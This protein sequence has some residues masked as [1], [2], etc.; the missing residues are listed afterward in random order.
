MK[1]EC[2]QLRV[3]AAEL[4]IRLSDEIKAH[5]KT[6]HNRDFYRRR[7]ELLQREQS[8]MRDPERTIVCDI[9]ANGT[10]L[11]DPHGVRYGERLVGRSVTKGERP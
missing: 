2:E 3:K 8:R 10:L 7:A 5:K 4:E 11:P 6:A 1:E 9:L